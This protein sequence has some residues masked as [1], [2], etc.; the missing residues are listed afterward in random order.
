MKQI[1]T[2]IT[3][4]LASILLHTLL[5]SGV[6]TGINYQGRYRENQI[7]VTGTRAFQFRITNNDG[8]VVYWKS[9]IVNLQVEK[10]LFNYVLH[11]STVDWAGVSPFL[12]VRVGPEG[13]TDE[14]ALTVLLPREQ[15][16]ASAYAFYASSATYAGSL[17]G[18]NSTDFVRRTGNISE[19]I[20]GAK[21]F[22]S[23]VTITA[24][25]GLLLAGPIVPTAS[26]V[27]VSGN[28]SLPEGAT[29]YYGSN[30]G[31]IFQSATDVRI[32]P[33]ATSNPVIRFGGTTTGTGGYLRATRIQR[34]DGTNMITLG[35]DTQSNTGTVSIW[36]NLRVNNGNIGRGI[37]NYITMASGASDNITLSSHTK[38]VGQLIVDGNVGIGTTAPQ[39]KLDVNGNIQISNATIPMGLMTE[40]GG[41][42]PLL[43]FSVNFREPNKNNTYRGAAFRIDTRDTQPLFQW[44]TRSA[45]STTENVRM[46]LTE[47]GN[48]GIGTTVPQA[49]FHLYTG[50]FLLGTSSS[51][52]LRIRDTGAAVDIESI[53]VPLYIN[54]TTGQNTYIMGGNVGIGTT[55]PS[56][57]LEVYQGNIAITRPSGDTSSAVLYLNQNNATSGG[58]YA[59]AARNTGEFAIRDMDANTDRVVISTMGNVGIGTTNPDATSNTRCIHIWGPGTNGGGG[60]IF[61]GDR[62][63]VLN[64]CIGEKGTDD[65]DILFIYGRL[66]IEMEVN[67]GNGVPAVI[68]NTN[69]GSGKYFIFLSSYIGS[70]GTE[71]TFKPSANNY[72]TLGV[73]NYAWW[74]SYANSHVDTSS[75]KWKRDI[76]KIPKE[77]FKEMYDKV[78]N[79]ELVSYKTVKEGAD[80]KEYLAEESFGVIS[81]DAPKEIVD[82]SGAGIK[83]YQYISL[84]V[85]ALK[86][87][88]DKIEQLEKEIEELKKKVR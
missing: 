20:T 54:N 68:I 13:T 3:Y 46:V 76:K 74:R 14:N 12:E 56:Q 39:S 79:I 37:V 44:L 41:T 38:I 11:C 10:G 64:P 26:T 58:N 1:K 40:V 59:I 8:T 72:G 7:F 66:G 34:E 28:L 42:T 43:N 57:K 62:Q 6:P 60:R 73:A 53:G 19:S 4:I 81:E 85:G 45:G 16:M 84:V 61:F 36:G 70:A 50:T 80:G 87:A 21:T 51:K 15:I 2:Q 17:D 23:S 22:T 49:N 55:A 47:G 83:L 18:L 5:Y 29:V 52:Q 86:E 71:P 32:V 27:T 63:N 35:P 88:Q 82:E 9:P 31:I 33:L 48:V 78:R 77:K 67:A 69:S 30:T 75:R 65:T 24:T 25:D